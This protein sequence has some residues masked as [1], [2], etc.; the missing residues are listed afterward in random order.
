MEAAHIRYSEP[1][2]AK[3]I[4]GIG[5]K[6]ANS[7]VVPLCGRHHRNQHDAGNE[8]AWWD[9]HLLDPIYISLALWHVSGDH[10]AG[11]QIIQSNR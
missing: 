6:A 8:R 2:A 7:F 9:A 10:E 4:T 3:P 1:R 11:L 5:T